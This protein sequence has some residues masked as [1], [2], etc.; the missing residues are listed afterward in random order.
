MLVYYSAKDSKVDFFQKMNEK[1]RGLSG[2]I[3]DYSTFYVS[4]VQL[5]MIH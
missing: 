1:H 5:K 4:P 3:V 2:V